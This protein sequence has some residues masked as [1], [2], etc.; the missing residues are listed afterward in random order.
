[1]TSKRVKDVVEAIGV[2]VIQGASLLMEADAQAA[3]RKELQWHESAASQL[4]EKLYKQ[5]T[6]M[7]AA[8]E[9]QLEA[10]RAE[11]TRRE[12]EHTQILEARVQELE[13]LQR[14]KTKVDKAL[15]KAQ[16][17]LKISGMKAEKD[18]AL[19]AQLRND[20]RGKTEALMTS[21]FNEL[22]LP[23]EQGQTPGDLLRSLVAS[24]E[25]AQ[26][27]LQTD[28]AAG[29]KVIE[30]LRKDAAEGNKDIHDERDKAVA[31]RDRM[32]ADLDEE[33]KARLLAE[34]ESDALRK[35][36]V[37]VRRQ[38]KEDA[39]GEVERLEA[40]LAQAHEALR[41]RQSTNSQL[42]ADLKGLR[43]ELIAS[44]KALRMAQAAGRNGG[45]YFAA[46]PVTMTS[47]E[48]SSPPMR[49]TVQ[50]DALRAAIMREPG[51][52]ELSP[53][54]R[55]AAPALER[56]PTTTPQPPPFTHSV[57]SASSKTTKSSKGMSTRGASKRT[58]R[59][60][61][62]ASSQFAAESPT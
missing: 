16:T 6:T 21:L 25:K 59:R 23:F 37:Q 2:R 60:R 7:E 31:G 50:T 3:R 56:T 34:T 61:S 53:A 42:E 14:A 13:K 19:I 55:P 27:E 62:P 15:T 11:A 46:V 9:K 44:T 4:Q 58:A 54:R 33:K 26:K 47:Y 38:A 10:V 43:G 41:E 40:D 32:A 8:T 35:E 24:H 1:M 22:S 5:A 18:E 57:A 45:Y 48:M 39:R 12:E 17:A 29:A 20:I 51:S 49:K 52:T 28:L 36:Q 30:A